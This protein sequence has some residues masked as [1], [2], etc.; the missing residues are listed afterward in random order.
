MPTSPESISLCLKGEVIVYNLFCSD[1]DDDKVTLCKGM[2]GRQFQSCSLHH[3]LTPALGFLLS[4]FT[5]FSNPSMD[6]IWNFPYWW[7]NF[8]VFSTLKRLERRGSQ[9]ESRTY[10][11]E[12]SEIRDRRKGWDP[13]PQTLPFFVSFG[14]ADMQ[15]DSRFLKITFYE[16]AELDVGTQFSSLSAQCSFLYNQ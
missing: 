8:Y 1:F 2:L 4:L 16:I 13:P 15:R 7:S 5:P 11:Q 10:N 14:E 6:M 3:H 12:A 9:L